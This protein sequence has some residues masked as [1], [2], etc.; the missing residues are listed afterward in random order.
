MRKTI[1]K[2]FWIW[3]FDKE[4]EW[5]NQMAAKGLA[6][7][8]VGY[9]R[10]DFEDCTPGEYKVRL[11][12]LENSKSRYE[13]DNYIAFLEDTGA[14]HLG[15]CNRWAYFRKKTE[16]DFR[17]FSDSAS[18]IKHLTRVIGLL[19]LLSLLNLFIG[20]YNVFVSFYLHSIFNLC[21]MINLLIALFC[22]PGMARLLM[23]R[24]SLKR[25]QQIY[26]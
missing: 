5:L 25:E 11:E 13:N 1:H 8:A 18:L 17:L 19:A 4:E 15:N 9:C 12:F 2:L 7:I 3:D 22:L 24:R 26:E 10:Y 14:E 16:G 23:K 20:C 21:G 6:L